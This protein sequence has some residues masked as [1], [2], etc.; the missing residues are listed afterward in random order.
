ME[1]ILIIGAGG[2][3]R[4]VEW[5]INRINNSNNN[6]WNLIGYVDDNIQKGTAIT[7]LKV[8]YN[9][10]E[11]LK[12]EEK[13]NVVI[14]I[15]NAKVRKLIYNKIKE[16]KNLSFPNLVDPSAI[17]GEVDMGIGNIICAGTIA[18]VNIK[19]NNFNIIN[20]DCTIGHD[21]VLTDFITVYPSVN[22]S[23]NTTINEVVEI[24][25]GTQIIQGKNICS[26]VIIGAG[27]VVVKDIAEEGTY[28]GIPVK[29]IE[30]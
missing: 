23:G 21:D 22:I 19:I 3:G 20:L 12:L 27:A 10:D 9:T 18:T 14:A 6:Q 5:L 4:E 29:K 1:N 7:K 2:F 15:G 8:V 26:N 16:N 24:G 17:I 11:L 25:T 28:V 13:T 30:K